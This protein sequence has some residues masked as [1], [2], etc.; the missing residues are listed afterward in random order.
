MAEET[1]AYRQ[2]IVGRVVSNKMDK[3]IVVELVRQVRH[4]LYKKYMKVTKKFHAHDEENACNMGDTVK[5]V[6]CRPLSKT[7]T[8][9]LEEVIERS[10]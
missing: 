4:K 1:I 8:W 2:T 6:E 3:T 7:K 10:S 9:V 5:I